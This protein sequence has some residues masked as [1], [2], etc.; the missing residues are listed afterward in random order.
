MEEKTRHSG[1]AGELRCGYIFRYY[2]SDSDGVLDHSDVCR[3]ISNMKSK[4]KESNGFLFN[5][6]VEEVAQKIIQQIGSNNTI[7]YSQFVRAVGS[8]K[9]R[10]T[11]DLFGSPIA[12]KPQQIAVEFSSETTSKTNNSSVSL[13]MSR[14]YIRF[15]PQCRQRSYKIAVHSFEYSNSRFRSFRTK[16]W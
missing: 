10:G 2:D 16:I 3:L 12:T 1:T 13:A 11:S 7:T 14:K 9:F 6:G 5:A 8:L 15:Y 4:S